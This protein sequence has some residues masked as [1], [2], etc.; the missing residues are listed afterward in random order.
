MKNSKQKIITG[1]VLA[2]LIL[3]SGCSEEKGNNKIGR[4][5]IVND[6]KNDGVFWVDT[7]TG[8]VEQCQWTEI[9]SEHSWKC[10]TVKSSEL[11]SVS[12]Q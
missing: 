3:L 6:T 11:S 12:N 8:R 2:N 4:Y 10:F 1:F 7:V 9:G 5:Q